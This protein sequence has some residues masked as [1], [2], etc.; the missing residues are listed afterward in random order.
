MKENGIMKKDVMGMDLP[1]GIYDK[2]KVLRNSVL[3]YR[4]DDGVYHIRYVN[5]YM[6]LLDFRQYLTTGHP[7]NRPM[8][9]VVNTLMDYDNDIEYKAINLIDYNPKTELMIL[10]IT[11][12]ALGHVLSNYRHH[13]K[14]GRMP[15]VVANI[16]ND[17]T[18]IRIM[19][20]SYSSFGVKLPGM[21]QY[22]DTTVPIEC[23]ISKA[24]L[25]THLAT[26]NMRTN[27]LME[28]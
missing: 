16:I 13:P 12:R 15:Y 21:I 14:V 26:K 23:K 8:Y 7:M 3:A 11:T 4:T 1:K 9:S 18:P 24:L 25:K 27:W 19:T 2:S 17:T 10:N 5:R 6:D 20:E 28:G 22:L